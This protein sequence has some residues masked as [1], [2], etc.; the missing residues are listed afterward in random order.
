MTPVQHSERIHLDPEELARQWSEHE[1]QPSLA[2]WLDPQTL[3]DLGAFDFT[4]AREFLPDL[5]RIVVDQLQTPP[6]PRA[7]LTRIVAYNEA[8]DEAVDTWAREHGQLAQAGDAVHY[9]VPLLE[10]ALT[11]TLGAAP[12]GCLWCLFS[13]P[14]LLGAYPVQNLPVERV[15]GRKLDYTEWY[16]ARYADLPPPSTAPPVLVTPHPADETA[17]LVLEGVYRLHHAREQ[18][19][20]EIR[21]KLV[22]QAQ[23]QAFHGLQSLRGKYRYEL[24][25][26]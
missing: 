23:W 21:A 22:G 26:T 24:S 25:H 10:P 20:Q 11:Q 4:Q 8:V 12:Q 14:L 5:Y 16:S 9:Q 3:P 13:L 15:Q 7:I 17:Y 18:G 2:Q 19:H 1:P 6:S